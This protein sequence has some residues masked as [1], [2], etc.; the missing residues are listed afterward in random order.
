MTVA[1]PRDKRELAAVMG[2]IALLL[3]TLVIDLASPLGYA[4]WAIYLVPVGL[5][6]FQRDARCRSSWRARPR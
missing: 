5:A 4:A 1:S 3:L 2:S 6:L